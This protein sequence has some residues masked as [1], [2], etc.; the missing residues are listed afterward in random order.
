[1]Q[2]KFIHNTTIHGCKWYDTTF[3]WVKYLEKVRKLL[4]KIIFEIIYDILE[5]VLAILKICW[6][7]LDLLLFLGLS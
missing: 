3:K 4:D 2:I 6:C 5:F 7:I 1:M